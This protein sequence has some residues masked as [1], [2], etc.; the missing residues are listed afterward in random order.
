MARDYRLPHRT[1][2]G[3]LRAMPAPEPQ[4]LS[5]RA[6]APMFLVLFA[7]A[8]LPFMVC[9]IL[10]LVDYPNHLARM[11]VLA[12]LPHD[13]TLAQFYRVVWQPIPNLAMDAIVPPLLG[14]MP[15]EVAGKSFVLL[16]FLLLAGGPALL[17]RALTGRW[18][19]W[20][21]LAFLFLFGRLLLWGV[22]N[23]L[24]GLGLAFCALALL[25]AIAKRGAGLRLI[26][27]SIAAVAIYFA[28]LMAFGIY[29]LIL[30]GI[31][32]TPLLRAPGQTL[33]RLAIAALPLAVPL[34][35]WLASGS[36]G[37]LVAFSPPLRKLDLLYSTFDLYHRPFDIACFALFVMV[38]AVAF[39]RRWLALA[40][41][42]ALP[43]A[44][45]VLAYLVMPTQIAGASGVDRRMPLAIALLLCAGTSW[46][47]PRP[48]LEWRLLG[49]AAVMFVVRIAAVALSW[50]MSD[51]E[52]RPLVASLDTLPVG[53]RLAIAAPPEA[54][55]VQ[56]TPLLHLPTLAVAAR[57]A[58]VPTL[59]A[60]PGQQPVAFQPAFAAL[61]AETSP[62][63]VWQAY[64]AGGPPL[65]LAESA[66]LGR[67]D[68]VVFIG[69]K[70]FSLVDPAGLQPVLVT[71]RWKLYRLGG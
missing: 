8:A 49:A 10:P 1:A 27:G 58:F 48:Q 38:L 17:H 12:R 54:V 5:P 55:N 29:A 59:F 30:I 68:F 36:G 22:L 70:P 31:E 15:L 16:T 24:F 60:L 44:L 3:N 66:A 6:F 64:V 50:H 67:F 7:I 53:A 62:D 2:H 18:S 71:P 45:L 57:D 47:A 56:A 46:V 52:Y 40:P 34:A 14:S 25:A 37:A 35:I 11:A 23:Y 43:L 39:G 41:S 20:T 65:D 63:R 19:V 21:L 13:A 32:A 51:V 33:R 61:A 4:H 69:V 28:H 42:F 9:G 26:V